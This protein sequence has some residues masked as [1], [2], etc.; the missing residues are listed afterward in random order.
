MLSRRFCLKS[1]L[2]LYNS[3]VLST[4]LY[5]CESWNL[6]TTEESKLD[7]FD[8]KCLRRI[9]HI[10]WNDFITN[11][12][13]RERT[14]Q[15]PVSSI[16]CKRRLKWLGHA[17]RLPPDRIANQSLWWVPPG[18]RRRGR[19]RMNWQQTVC[20]DVRDLNK[21]EDIKALAADRRS[22]KMMTASCVERRGSF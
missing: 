19:P 18:R 14:N 17:A 21:W 16:I 5:G 1:K 10:K 6:K 13:V 15:L 9:L 20:R 4:L 3:N 12:E 11:K 8:T 7:A 2:R 22:W